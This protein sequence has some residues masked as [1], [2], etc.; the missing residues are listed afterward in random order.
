[1]S[2]MCNY[3]TR[4]HQFTAV[5]PHPPPFAPLLSTFTFVPATLRYCHVRHS[6][7]LSLCV[8]LK[9]QESQIMICQ[10]LLSEWHERSKVA[11]TTQVTCFDNILRIRR[12]IYPIFFSR[13]L[14]KMID[15]PRNVLLL[16]ETM[17]Q[18]AFLSLE[19]RLNTGRNSACVTLAI[20]HWI[21]V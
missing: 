9:L 7:V 3:S 18:S 17:Y 16:G 5:L 10:L 21:V 11:H 8:L 13:C 12:F 4:N 1:M 20:V 2:R 6:Q 19:F 15:L 14:I